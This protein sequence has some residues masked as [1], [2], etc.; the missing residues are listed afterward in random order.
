MKAINKIYG[1]M[2]SSN[3]EQTAQRVPN[4]EIRIPIVRV[5]PQPRRHKVVS[6]GYTVMIDGECPDSYK[7]QYPPDSDAPE[8]LHPGVVPANY[9]ASV[10]VDNTAVFFHTREGQIGPEYQVAYGHAENVIFGQDPDWIED[11][12]ALWIESLQFLE[13]ENELS[14]EALNFLDA[15]PLFLFGIADPSTQAALKKAATVPMLKCMGQRP[16]V[17][18][19]FAY[20][21][22]DPERDGEY[23]WVVESFAE[24]ELP[25]PWTSFK[26]AGSIVCYL[27]NDTNETTW[28]HPFYDYFAQLLDHCRRSTREE[29]LKLRINRM[30]WSYEAESEADVQNQHPLISPKYVKQMAEILGVVLSG[31]SA[32]PIMVRVIKTFLKAFS[33]QRN[34]EDELDTQEV[35]WCLEIVENERA[36]S[37]ITADVISGRVEDTS[38]NIRANVHKQLYC[39]ECGVVASCYCIQCQDCL[40]ENCFEKLHSKGNRSLH[41]GNHIIPC[42]LCQSMPAKL[43]C[44]YTFGNYC[45]QCY[46]Q[47]HVKSLPKFLD[48][49]PMRIDYT[50]KDV[51]RVDYSDEGQDME[52]KR[53]WAT[54]ETDPEEEARGGF[55]K[56][57]PAETT[58]GD[59]W[60]AF[61]DLR[62]VKYYYNFETEESL[63]RPSLERLDKEYA[64]QKHQEMTGDKAYVLRQVAASKEPRLLRGWSLAHVKERISTE[65]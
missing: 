43:Q 42:C 21:N 49:K 28:K 38:E 12:D 3:A 55:S 13:E 25:A 32:E 48:L 22:A 52:E 8:S 23:R 19:W 63:R 47:K 5:K 15:D 46:S 60:H 54:G 14:E 37:Q 4:P 41:T 56:R 50:K 57:A 62:G 34:I 2:S 24:V 6:Y 16:C 10:P 18:E 65:E 30:L 44:T 20:L 53:V 45:Q 1:K 64:A 17:E 27:N 51:R 26:G 11:V 29:H 59:K 36:K 7:F 58:L 40:C 9:S 33:Q 39:I 61:Y 35:K 31:E